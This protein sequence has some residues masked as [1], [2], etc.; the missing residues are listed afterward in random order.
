MRGTIFFVPKDEGGLGL[1]DI[2]AQQRLL[3]FRLIK[4]LLNHINTATVNLPEYSYQFM[5]STLQMSHDC[6]SHEI[7]LLFPSA[8]AKG[9]L[10]G[11]HSFKMIFEALD[12]C[13]A[14]FTTSHQ[15]WSVLPSAETCLLLPLIEVCTL[16]TDPL[17]MFKFSEPI[18][19]SRV[20]DFFKIDIDSGLVIFKEKNRMFQTKRSEQ[21]QK[22]CN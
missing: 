21:D 14:D 7:P 6:P 19:E 16:S 13:K 5:V 17:R 3:P 1:I 10:K 22:G 4:A 12:C 2:P 18:K 15:E 20:Q 11:N 9:S 8:R